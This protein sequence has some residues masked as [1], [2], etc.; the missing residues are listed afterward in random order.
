MFID[1]FA[2]PVAPV[3]L[4][5]PEDLTVVSPDDAT[6]FCQA[7]ARPGPAMT[8][9]RVEEDGSLNQI[10]ET[11]GE[12]TIVNVAVG[13][14]V[15]NSTLVVINSQ[16]SD[17]GTYFCQ[18]ENVFST[19]SAT[20]NFTVYGKTPTPAFFFFKDICETIRVAIYS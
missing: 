19:D 13:E 16:P 8:W 1:F 15:S 18:A 12:Y 20:V 14:R 4:I 10:V 7:T 3:I 5:P 11:V 17:A 6:F 9:W 2:L